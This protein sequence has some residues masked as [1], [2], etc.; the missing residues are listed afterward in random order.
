M[1][2]LVNFVEAVL[3]RAKTN[4]IVNLDYFHLM[5]DMNRFNSFS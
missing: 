5:E 1:L 2:S 4:V 3:V